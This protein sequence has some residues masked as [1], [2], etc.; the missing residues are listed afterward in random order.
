MAT[1]TVFGAKTLYALDLDLTSGDTAPL[2]APQLSA[3]DVF[4]YIAI[5]PT[6][7]ETLAVAT[8]E[9]D[10]FLSLD[11][12]ATWEQ[13]ADNGPDPAGAASQ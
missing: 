2:S 4:T 6:A 13:I 3:E 1:Y 5:S 7:P 11:G 9:R 12:G 10:V 8:L